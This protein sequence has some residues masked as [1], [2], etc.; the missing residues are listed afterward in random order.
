MFRVNALTLSGIAALTIAFT[1]PA[2]ASDTAAPAPASPAASTPA[3]PSGQAAQADPTVGPAG[4][5]CIDLHMIDHTKVVDNQTILFH[6]RGKKTY[7][8]KLPYRCHGLKFEEGFSYSTSIGKLCG[9][10]DTIRV[11]R[12]GNSCALGAFHEYIKPVKT[13]KE[14][15][16]Q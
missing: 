8:S 11:L 7:I 6:M 14:A 12:R 1:A 4:P 9:K 15:D 3:P 2:F 16:S 13:P 5:D 10:V